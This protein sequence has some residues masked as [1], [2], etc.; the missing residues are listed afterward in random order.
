MER[1]FFIFFI[2]ILLLWL[3]DGGNEGTNRKKN[4]QNKRKTNKER[5]RRRLV[6]ETN[7]SKDFGCFVTFL[8]CLFIFYVVLASWKNKFGRKTKKTKTNRKQKKKL[9]FR[10]VVNR[11][12]RDSKVQRD[13]R[14]LCSGGVGLG[15]STRR[16]LEGASACNA[17]DTGSNSSEHCFIKSLIALMRFEVWR[18]V[19]RTLTTI[20]C[21]DISNISA[22]HR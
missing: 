4:K 20:R 2:I 15:K 17:R 3:Y 22:C 21:E 13:L 11:L 1:W 7:E 8:S 5:D 10:G 14:G 12:V 6:S 9:T 16:W 19:A 18:A